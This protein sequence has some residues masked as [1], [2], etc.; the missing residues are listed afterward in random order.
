M[1]IYK[2]CSQGGR[3]CWVSGYTQVPTND[4]VAL[5]EAV[6]KQPVQISLSASELVFQNYES[7]VLDTCNKTEITVDHAVQL[8]GYGTETTETGGLDYWLVRNSWGTS[9]GE[10]GYIKM[11]RSSTPTC[12]LDNSMADGDGCKFG[13]PAKM[14]VCGKC[15]LLSDSTYPTDAFLW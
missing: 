11:A 13:T 4:Y 3:R 14:K 6:S 8:V 2:K 7:G 10:E 9:W 5:M 15:G 1:P 12:A